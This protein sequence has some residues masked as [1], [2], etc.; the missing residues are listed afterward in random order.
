MKHFLHISVAVLALCISIPFV[1]HAAAP[2]LVSIPDAVKGR[3]AFDGAI[4][5]SVT[6]GETLYLGGGFSTV[7]ELTGPAVKYNALTE[8]RN[9]DF[10]KIT[11]SNDG[12]AVYASISDGDGGWYVGGYF[13]TVGDETRNNL[14]HITASGDVDLDFNP[15]INSTV[16]ALALSSDGSILYAGGDFTVVNDDTSRNHLAA[17]TTSNGT[18]VG[19]NTFNPNVDSTVYALALSP[20]NAILYA[21]GEFE[22]V[23]GG[24]AYRNSLAAFNT[25]NGIVT[26]FDPSPN[27]TVYTLALSN[28]GV[29]LYTGGSF[30]DVNNGTTRNFLAAFNTTTSVATSFDPNAGSTVYASDLSSDGNILYVG[31][32]FGAIGGE[33]RVQ[34]AAIDTGTGLATSLDAGIPPG[35][36]LT[37][38]AVA[39]SNDESTVYI[40]GD[41]QL[42]GIGGQDR[43]YFG[44]VDT[45]TGLATTLNPKFVGSVYTISYSP[46]D[47]LF[48]GGGFSTAE[49]VARGE[50]AAIDLTTYE[51]T[52]FDPD[53]TGVVDGTVHALALSSD[54]SI[55]YIG[56]GI[57]AVNNDTVPR[58]NLLS[59]YTASG[60]ATMFD[61]DLDGRAYTLELSSD[62]NTLYVGGSFLTVNGGDVI[63]PYLT[64]FDI[65]TSDATGFLPTVDGYIY[66]ISLSSDDSVVY[67]T[68]DSYQI[69]N[70]DAAT[71]DALGLDHTLNDSGRTLALS[72]DDSI[73]YIGG[74][75][76]SLTQ[77]VGQGAPFNETT[78]EVIGEYPILTTDLNDTV[79]S[80]IPD[81]NGGWYVGGDFDLIDGVATTHERLVHILPDYTVDASFNAIIDGGQVLSMTLSPN[82]DTLYVG[83]TFTTVNVGTPRSKIVAFDTD[84]GSVLP[85]NPN[86]VFTWILPYALEISPDGATLYAGGPSGDGGGLIAFDTATGDPALVFDTDD[87]AVS[88]VVRALELSP[89]GG[90]LYVG[91]DFTNVDNNVTTRNNIAAFDTG[92]G[93]ASDVPGFDPNSN[94]TVYTLVMKNSDGLRLYAGGSFSTIGGQSRFEFAEIDTSTGLATALNANIVGNANT[95]HAIAP[96]SDGTT[97][98]IGGD[99]FA[100]FGGEVRSNFAEIDATTGVP[101]DFNPQFNSTVQAI[102]SSGNGEVYVGGS[103][104]A[105]VLSNSHP[106]LNAIDLSDNTLTSFAPVPDD[107][108]RTIVLSSD[109]SVL[110][111]G[112][113]FTDVNSGTTRNYLAVFDTSDGDATDF[114]P[115]ES[116]M[117]T[118]YTLTLAPDDDELY[119]GGEY[120]IFLV[121]DEETVVE[122]E[123]PEEGDEGGGGGR[124]VVTTPM[125]TSTP[126]LL[127][128]LQLQLIELLTQYLKLLLGAQV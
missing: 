107:D 79:Y 49:T 113:F 65:T 9:I 98:Y 77:E 101:T 71:G 24:D 57:S 66:A 73:L 50:V 92:T 39:L 94:S 114:A 75:F 14:V 20:N 64:A 122:D 53:I 118:A 21:G 80:V 85:F 116:D 43:R 2:E 30:T 112:G 4:Y 106:Y 89:D 11:Q 117:T 3:Y 90:I 26:T 82:G 74:G 5:A 115:S 31:G 36:D 123:A 126:T 15:N 96:S 54:S 120:G 125:P 68:G 47:T 8:E 19:L 61:P 1:L 25:S 110:Y 91:G 127:E 59:V 33:A 13:D 103:F 99:N 105:M 86:G 70:F 44:A 124:R 56:G 58:N 17:F 87:N 40:G 83:G 111:A 100:T 52:D 81:G 104:T 6:D 23:N 7:S 32:S 60:D 41:E 121:F 22:T 67:A 102:A 51:L 88:G 16:R 84:D 42:N 12:A 18:V 109:D 95:V 93:L 97:V 108:V 128:Q 27:S 78:Q 10:P 72:S 45:T 34:F 35:D 37:V 48:V 29:T 69:Q 63:Q 38:Y 28:N 119:F 76:T 62:N 46:Q 55:L